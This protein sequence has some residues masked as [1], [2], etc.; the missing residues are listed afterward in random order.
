M[1]NR[2]MNNRQLIR[3]IKRVEQVILK[4]KNNYQQ[5]KAEINEKISHLE[6]NY[7]VLLPVAGFVLG[8]VFYKKAFFRKA[9]WA[10]T[11]MHFLR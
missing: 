7:G 9:L 10:L 3:E 1:N 8:W 11:K 2:H 5:S 6:S 4:N